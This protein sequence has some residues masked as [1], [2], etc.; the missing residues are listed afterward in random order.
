MQ[1]H[2]KIHFAPQITVIPSGNPEYDRSVAQ[3]VT[4]IL[5][6]DLSGVLLGDEVALRAD[7]ALTDRSDT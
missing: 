2:R 5:R 4:D 6:R 1:Q 3:E 7:A